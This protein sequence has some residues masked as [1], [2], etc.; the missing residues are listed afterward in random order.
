MSD[1]SGVISYCLCTRVD[2]SAS[3]LRVITFSVSIV[4]RFFIRSAPWT[5]VFRKMD[6]MNDSEYIR[7]LGLTRTTSCR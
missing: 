6:E 4:T 2:V 3:Q 1:V 5:I 7:R